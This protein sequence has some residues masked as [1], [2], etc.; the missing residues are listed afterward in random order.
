[1]TI[2]EQADVIVERYI[3][4]ADGGP[5]D[6][7]FTRNR[8]ATLCAIKEVEARIEDFYKLSCVFLKWVGTDL[9]EVEPGHYTELTAILN[10]LKSRI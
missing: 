10:E 7:D 2:R 8:G 5:E 3:D 4:Y 1:M 6:S 9:N